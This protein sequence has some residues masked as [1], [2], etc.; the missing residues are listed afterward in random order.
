LCARRK[1]AWRENDCFVERSTDAAS[2]VAGLQFLQHPLER[3]AAHFLAR[4]ELLEC[5]QEPSDE[6]LRRDQEEDA[7]E[8]PVIVVHAFVIADLER[9]GP[10]I[11]ELGDTKF[12]KRILPDV[13]A[14]S[15][16]FLEDNLP[17]V[18]AERDQRGVVR[19]ADLRAAEK[20]LTRSN[21]LS[22]L[23]ARRFHRG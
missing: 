23:L 2:V 11:E 16:L 8:P 6:G 22:S 17:L 20:N 13:E 7:L 1:Q 3:E 10:Q 14:M 18:V 12:G 5:R 15:A 21:M 4:W 9:I 19:A